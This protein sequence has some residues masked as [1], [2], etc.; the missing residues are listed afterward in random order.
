M[1][2][3]ALSRG[4]AVMSTALNNAG[5]NCNVVTQAESMV[6]A[7]ERLIEQLRRRS[8]TRSA[9]AA[10][11]ARSP[12]SRS[13]T[14][15]PASTRAS[16]RPCSFPDAWSTGQQLADYHLVRGYVEDPTQVG[17]RRRSGTRCRSPRSRAIP[18]TSTRSSS[19]PS[20]GRRSAI[21]DDGCPGVPA[22]D[23]YNAQTN[24][25]GVRCTLADYMI[26]VFGP[27]PSSLWGPPSSRSATASPACRS[28]TSAS[29]TGSRRSRPGAIT[30]AQFV[31]LNDKVG[32]A[33][34][35]I[36]HDRRRAA[37]PTS[38]R[39]RNAYRSGGDQRGQQPRPAS[40]SSTCAAPTRARSTTPTARGRSARGSSAST[41]R[42][43]N[44]VI[45]F[46]AVP[47]M[48][49]AQLRDRGLARD[50]P[51][52]GRGRERTSAHG[53]LAQKIIRDR[54]RDVHDRCSQVDGVELVTCRASARSASSRRSQTRFGTPRTVAGEGIETDT[55]KC[56][57]KPLRRTR[58]LPDHVHRRPVGAAAVRRS[59]PASATGA[60]RASSQQ[61]TIP[62]QTYQNADGA[63]I[64]GG[65]PLGAAPG[66]LGR[67]LDERRVRLVAVLEPSALSLT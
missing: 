52:A 30:P 16:C 7:K 53:T 13:P 44:Q 39:W 17:H 40:R 29:S 56:T 27:R 23:N 65:T 2:D 31:D 57:L 21:P 15:T 61:G 22:E 34:I 38:P 10:R 47:L 55:N 37:A 14:P 59:R 62:W 64:Y 26:N 51:V 49:D 8:A 46:G 36:N 35:D 63:V 32:G 54:P 18:T 28:T 3:T 12:S 5:H 60:G 33:D 20:T 45:W 48:G 24:P 19:T 50:G 66:G 41:A 25:G 43:A 58:L 1:N 11:A 9:P 42:Y 6:M 67:R 4:F